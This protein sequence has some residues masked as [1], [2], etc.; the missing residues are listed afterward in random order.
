[1]HSASASLAGGTVSKDGL[2]A[3]RTSGCPKHEEGGHG[4]PPKRKQQP[5]APG[6]T[7]GR[8][9]SVGDRALYVSTPPRGHGGGSSLPCAA[10]RPRSSESARHF[11][12]RPQM[13]HSACF[14]FQHSHRRSY[15]SRTYLTSSSFDSIV[16]R[17]LVRSVSLGLSVGRAAARRPNACHG[18][19][20][21][22]RSPPAPLPPP[23]PRVCMPCLLLTLAPTSFGRQVRVLLL[24][25]VKQLRRNLT[26]TVCRLGACVF[27][28]ALAKITLLA[29]TAAIN[30]EKFVRGIL[31][32]LLV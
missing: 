23:V 14:H 29:L 32:V 8:D 22:V 24:K 7:G 30:N 16:S 17:R 28:M 20:R 3:S 12:F 4:A 11:E 13:Y 2:S 1:M 26:S 6:N 9:G 25:N 15:S 21:A 5:K 31:D 19:W 27:F 10:E 18:V